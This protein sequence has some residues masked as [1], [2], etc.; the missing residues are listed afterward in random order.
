ML[1]TEKIKAR[2]LTEEEVKALG[3]ETTIYVGANM[4]GFPPVDCYA[5]AHLTKPGAEQEGGFFSVKSVFGEIGHDGV[6][7]GDYGIYVADKDGE[8]IEVLQ[9]AGLFVNVALFFPGIG[10]EGLSKFFEAVRTAFK[11]TAV[12]LFNHAHDISSLVPDVKLDVYQVSSGKGRKPAEAPKPLRVAD[13]V[14]PQ[15]A[16]FVPIEDGKKMEIR[17]H[18]EV[19]KKIPTI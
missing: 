17:P 8:E 6:S 11:G 13:D 12:E 18:E 16:P 14:Y 5:P 7:D 1:N 9:S 10:E 3:T 15:Y 4:E 19:A 2:R